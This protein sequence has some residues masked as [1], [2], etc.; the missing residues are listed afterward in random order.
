LLEEIIPR[1][2]PTQYQCIKKLLEVQYYKRQIKYA[3]NVVIKTLIF[4]Q[5]AGNGTMPVKG[6]EFD[7]I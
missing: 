4:L 6:L 5:K 2:V 3:R 1:V 7:K